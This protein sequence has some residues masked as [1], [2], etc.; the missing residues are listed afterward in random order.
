MS[1]GFIGFLLSKKVTTP[2]P[3]RIILGFGCY[4]GGIQFSRFA[5]GNPNYHDVFTVEE[6]MYLRD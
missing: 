1:I 3:F 5:F 6:Y 4:L 2:V